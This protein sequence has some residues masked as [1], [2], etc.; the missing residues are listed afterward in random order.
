MRSKN[1][2]WSP[3]VMRLEPQKAPPDRNRRMPAARATRRRPGVP[4]IARIRLA[5]ALS[6]RRIIGSSS[7]RSLRPRSREATEPRRR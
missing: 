1:R 5:V 4:T 3:A 7:A 2:A 6:E